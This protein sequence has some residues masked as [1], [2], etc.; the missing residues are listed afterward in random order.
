MVTITATYSPED[1]KLRLYPSS[2]LDAE[3]Y[4]RVKAAG[5]KWAPRQ[6]LF[7]A[8]SWSPDREDLA[9]ELAGEIEPEEMTL[10]ERAQ[11]KAERLEEL[12]G[13]R[14]REANAFAR[15][16]SE[17]SEAFYMGQPILVGHHSERKARK[18]QERMHAAQAQASKAHKTANYWLYRASGVEH[19]ANMKNNPRTRANRIKT[20]LADLRELQ[21]GINTAHRALSIWE[22]AQTD[23]Q[24]TLALGHIDSR[25]T[26]SGWSDYSDVRDGKRTPAEVRAQCIARAENIINGPKRRRCIEHILNRL[27]FERA[28]LGD[29]A[30]YEGALTPVILQAFAREHGAE[31]PKVTEIEPGSFELESPV[32]LPLHLA[33]GRWLEMD[34]D[35]WRDLMQSVGYEVPAPKNALPPILNV[36]AQTLYSP[37]RAFGA[38]GEAEAW[39]VVPVT[40]AQLDAVY[41]DARGVRTSACGQFRFRVASARH[42]KI[43]GA[44]P[45]TWVA[46]FLTD[47]KA[48]PMPESIAA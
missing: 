33:S 44:D 29:V 45:W 15:R 20:L 43:E 27:A 2:R 21:R 28:M 4:E 37:S 1:N 30:R 32:P 6:E 41:A 35:G 31:K 46:V 48:H 36:D 23:E 42:L 47:S 18:T 3:T 11:A 25:E 40:K 38:R 24:I 26:C 9:V 7:V 5:F 14:Q 10:A 22:K 16:A 12:A 17:L 8:P 13:K 39:R 19:F 34:A